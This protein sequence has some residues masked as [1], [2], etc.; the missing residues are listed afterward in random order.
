[1]PGSAAM[2]DPLTDAVVDEFLND[3]YLDPLASDERQRVVAEGRTGTWPPQVDSDDD[4]VMVPEIAALLRRPP[5]C[6]Y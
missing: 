6:K 1:M 4:F 5:Y 3:V 2:S